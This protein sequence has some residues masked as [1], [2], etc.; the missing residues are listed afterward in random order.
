[1]DVLGDHPGARAEEN[2]RGLDVK[3]EVRQVF[4]TRADSA[5]VGVHQL[6]MA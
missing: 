2:Q 1:M 5:P 3:L 4:G 6:V